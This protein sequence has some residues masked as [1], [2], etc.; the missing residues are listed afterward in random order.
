MCLA[1]ATMPSSATH[2]RTRSSSSSD[3]APSA[4]GSNIAPQ[5]PALH[6]LCALLYEFVLAMLLL[7]AHGIPLFCRVA[8]RAIFGRGSGDSGSSSDGGACTF[9]EGTVWHTRKAPVKNSF[10]YPARY[11]LV[12][13]DAA[14]PPPV[15]CAWL[16]ADRLSADEA[17]RFAGVSSGRVRLLFMPPSAGYQENPLCVYY[18]DGADGCTSIGSD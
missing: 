1:D 2:R 8:L 16:L 17:R 11:C 6:M 9:Y 18:V 12:D 13:L 4:D 7:V 14:Q 15:W 5:P 3:S 10:T